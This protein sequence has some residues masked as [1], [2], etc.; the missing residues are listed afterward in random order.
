MTVSVAEL[1][2]AL[3]AA[4]SNAADGNVPAA[5]RSQGGDGEFHRELGRLFQVSPARAA[6]EQHASGTSADATH[7]LSQQTEPATGLILPSAERPFVTFDSTGIPAQLPSELIQVTVNL[8][9]L[10]DPSSLESTGSLRLDLPLTS[11]EP[12]AERQYQVSQT[13]V[14]PGFERATDDL[15]IA[16]IQFGSTF[17]FGPIGAHENPTGLGPAGRSGLGRTLLESV[18]NP[19][20]F[21]V[22]DHVTLTGITTG[23]QTDGVVQ[24][25]GIAD[26]PG[27]FVDG[28][29]GL[30]QLAPLG[31]IAANGTQD[32]ETESVEAPEQTGDRTDVQIILPFGAERRP[33][34]VNTD[35]AVRRTETADTPVK[36]SEDA[37][38]RPRVELDE[39]HSE[40]VPSEQQSD[41]AVLQP[42]DESIEPPKS[43]VQDNEPTLVPVRVR[44]GTATEPIV[45]SGD[46]SR[47]PELTSAGEVHLASPERFET[48]ATGANRTQPVSVD[49]EP[50][51]RPVSEF[52]QTTITLADGTE[53]PVQVD[54]QA[55]PA[56]PRTTEDRPQALQSRPV[57]FDPANTETVDIPESP[58]PG[59]N[60]PDAVG[61]L[62]ARAA[63]SNSQAVRPADIN[64]TSTRADRQLPP[65][66]QFI[67][68]DTVA[69]VQGR[70]SVT[71]PPT[72]P[73]IALEPVIPV[74][75]DPQTQSAAERP[76]QTG[77]PADLQEADVLPATYRAEVPTATGNATID[78]PVRRDARPTLETQPA[79]VTNVPDSAVPAA[80]VATQSARQDVP[81]L[82][83]FTGQVA[84]AVSQSLQREALPV[85]TVR[86]LTIRLDPPELGALRI[87]MRATDEGMAVDV[88]AADEVTLEMLSRRV[89]ELEQ[90]LRAEKAG[91][92]SLTVNRLSADNNE[93]GMSR[94]G[95]ESSS[96]TG[97]HGERRGGNESHSRQHSGQASQQ[98]EFAQRAV[99]QRSRVGVR[100]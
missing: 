77:Q 5:G 28:E 47:S 20:P 31:V 45:D 49:T 40:V 27:T 87:R 46:E 30:L 96:Q 48:V 82:L 8:P 74:D 34:V 72:R 61:N 33:S 21:S 19:G 50:S 80:G 55:L 66:S 41:S 62:S 54:L 79:A 37:L 29:A 23:Q 38:Q 100:A 91:V 14:A 51:Y 11:L 2:I 76:A 63:A 6:A 92:Q 13:P 60:N 81:V 59:G 53:I 75:V 68:V 9:S 25:R 36:E 15:L 10:I 64:Q 58:E 3:P 57:L 94:S 71:A 69:G 89:P 67:P 70:P 98:H 32:A 83:P 24:R 44:E 88:E 26:D 17:D 86:E 65:Q 93:S 22:S 85:D 12:V 43:E 99:P 78:R 73:P 18:P 95:D 7:L 42:A 16:R 90:L 35:K 4:E 39:P 52:G 84:N 56:V 97:T 1:L